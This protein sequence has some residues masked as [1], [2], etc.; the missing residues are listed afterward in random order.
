MSLFPAKLRALRE[1]HLSQSELAEHLGLTD[2]SHIAH[3]ETETRLGRDAASLLV[4]IKIA[5]L[6]DVSTDWLLRDTI[7]VLPLPPFQIIKLPV[8]G[9]NIAH[10]ADR[11]R[12]QCKRRNWT[13]TDLLTALSRQ[14]DTATVTRRTLNYLQRGER[15]PSI[16]LAVILADVFEL[17]LDYL[18]DERIPINIPLFY[19]H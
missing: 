4:C 13:T 6:F 11:L 17:P 10:F 9:V 19:R 3:I 5:R 18:L 12:Y 8:N 15:L 7:S 16:R 1:P 2:R 14:P